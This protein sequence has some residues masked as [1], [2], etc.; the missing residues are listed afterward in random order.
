MFADDVSDDSDEVVITPFQHQ[1]GG[2]KVVL[3]ISKHLICKPREEY[4]IEFYKR[5]PENLK[6]CVPHFRGEILVQYIEN[7]TGFQLRAQLPK[8]LKQDIQREVNACIDNRLMN[9]NTDISP[10]GLNSPVMSCQPSTEP[11]VLSETETEQHSNEK[12]H[13]SD[14]SKK[15]LER[16]MH[17]Y[18]LWSTNTSQQFIV[19]ENLLA[20][21]KFPCVLDIKLGRK[22]GVYDCSEEKRLILESRCAHSTSA[23]L[24]FRICGMQLFQ[25]NTGEYISQDKYIGRALDDE[26]AMLNLKQYF[27]DGFSLRSDVIR[28]MLEK[29]QYIHKTMAEQHMFHFLSVSLLL[30]YDSD[31]EVKVD[32]RLIDFA[33][34]IS[35]DDLPLEEQHNGYNEDLLFGISSINNILQ[36]LLS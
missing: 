15:C 21:Y 22:Q 5:L 28:K 17:K 6:D 35:Q 20:G 30:I 31:S 7:S 19:L 16:T 32:A 1:V 13:L 12:T 27:N 4:E 24:G 3:Q 10:D 26:G 18:A 11:E 36:G 2:H 8:G 23:S 34:A 14:W 29:L 9:N 25:R 33:N